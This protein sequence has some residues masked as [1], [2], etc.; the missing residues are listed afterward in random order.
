MVSS[1]SFGGT[2]TTDSSNVSAV[3]TNSVQSVMSYARSSELTCPQPHSSNRPSSLPPSIPSILSTPTPHS[4]SRLPNLDLA[5]ADAEYSAF[6]S[7][8]EDEDNGPGLRI[9]GAVDHDDL[10]VSD[11][12]AVE[13]ILVGAEE[14][15]QDSPLVEVTPPVLSR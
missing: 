6:L 12:E 3:A 9:E 15:G 14:G 2:S 7:G 13:A 11:G 5:G 8:S 10:G 1:S 4:N